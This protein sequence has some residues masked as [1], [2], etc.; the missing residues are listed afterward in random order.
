MKYLRRQAGFAMLP[1]ILAMFIIVGLISAGVMMLGPSVQRGKT[2]EAKAGLEKSVDAIISWSVANGRLPTELQALTIL[3]N[4]ND[5][6][7][8]PLI[9]TYDIN[10]TS[11]ATGGI[12][13][14]T[15]TTLF[16][17]QQIAFIMLSGGEDYQVTS[18]PS[19]SGPFSGSPTLQSNDLSRVVT[20]EELKNRAGCYGTTQGKLKILNNELPKGCVGTAYN[21]TIFGSGGVPPYTYSITGLPVTSGLTAT[22]TTISGSP[23]TTGTFPISV[24]VTDSQALTVQTVQKNINL[25]VASCAPPPPAASWNF[26]EGTGNTIGSGST[27]GTIAGT[28]TWVPHGSGSALSMN[29]TNNYIYFNDINYFNIGTGNVTLSAWVNLS[30][31]PTQ[32][33]CDPVSKVDMAI[34]AIAGKGF[35]FPAIGYGMYVTQTRQCSSCTSGC[36]AWSNYKA[37][38]QLRGPLTSDIHSVTSDST[39]H[40]AD[41]NWIHIAAVLDRSASSATDQIKLYINGIKQIDASNDYQYTSAT[42]LN[43]DNTFKFTIGARHD[44]VSGYAFPYW[45]LIDNVQFYKTALTDSQI[46]YLYVTGLTP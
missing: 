2:L 27:L 36:G 8:R 26:N 7:S 10:L 41:G 43:F 6:W 40:I 35:L 34:G 5:P 15:T 42:S 33:W 28:A 18:S 14:R 30:G 45:G 3:P 12:C 31:M 46:N 39:P 22:G 19:T 25:I 21:A 29:G 23:I 32:S 11:T 37:G 13:G 38:F 17:G 20:L 9:Y 4:P 16:S 44:G 1:I 24:T